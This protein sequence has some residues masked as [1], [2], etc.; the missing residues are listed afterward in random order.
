MKF[1]PNSVRDAMR[2][3]G[4]SITAVPVRL[5]DKAW[6][7]AL[8]FHLAG[9]ESKNDRRILAKSGHPF[10]IA[11]ETDLIEQAQAAIVVLRVEVHTRPENPLAGEIL[12]TPGASPAHHEVLSLLSQQPRLCWFFADD[13]FQMLYSQ[14]HPLTGEQHAEFS[15][16]MRD[17]VRHDTLIR[18]TGRYDAQAALSEIIGHYE[19]RAGSGAV[20]DSQRGHKA[21]KGH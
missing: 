18:C 14:E 8:F 10:P 2:T 21:E 20:F 7:A 17:A 12:L 3:G 9:P 1:F 4:A 16:L 5:D 6:E 11:L 15:E 19:P 13:D